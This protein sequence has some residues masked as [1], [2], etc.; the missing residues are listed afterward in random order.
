MAGNTTANQS[1]QIKAQV[2]S[3]FIL[4]AIQDGLLPMGLHRKALRV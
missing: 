3:E 2:Y 4:Q 1:P